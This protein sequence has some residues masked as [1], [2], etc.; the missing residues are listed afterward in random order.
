MKV[1]L[2]YLWLDGKEPQQFRGKT[3][4]VDYREP[5]WQNHQGFNNINNYPDWSFDGSS[6]NQ[7][8][9]GEGENTDCVIKPVFQCDDPFRGK[10]HKLVLCEVFDSDG[11]TPHK[12][13]KRHLLTTLLKS[14]NLNETIDHINHFNDGLKVV[15]HPSLEDSPWFG[16]E[17]EYTLMSKPDFKEGDGLPLGHRPNSEPREQGDYYCGIGSDNVVGRKIVEEHL[18]K[19]VRVGLDVSGVNA[20][21]LLGQWEYQIGPVTALNGSDQLWM[22]RY[23][24]ERVAENHGVII[25]YH[26]KPLKS[27]KWNGSGCHVNFSDKEMRSE[28]GIDKILETMESL[29]E[30][31]EEHIS[32]YGLYNEERSTGELETPD[33]NKFSYGYSTRDTSVRIPVQTKKEGKGYF[34]DRRPASNCDPYMV[35][36]RMLRTVYNTVEVIQ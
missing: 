29:S 14:I 25:S 18:E 23:I 8:K 5:R 13:N 35:S 36:E 1:F 10:P 32:V 24:L 33:I 21:V 15:R 9:A 16:W 30:N 22:S 31:H 34:E 12:T 7:A 26:P 3:K 4:V 6:T 20:E 11:V 28:G 17:Q 27:N 19:C 2:E